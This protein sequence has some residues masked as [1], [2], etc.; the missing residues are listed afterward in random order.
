MM[1]D[2]EGEGIDSECCK[3]AFDAQ[4]NQALGAPTWRRASLLG[5]ARCRALPLPSLTIATLHRTFLFVTPSLISPFP[6][7][8]G[9]RAAVCATAL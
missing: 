6:G 9:L 8:V 1:V 3:L 4:T 5:P 7:H 2:S